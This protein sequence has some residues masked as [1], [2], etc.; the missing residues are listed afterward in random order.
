ME[1]IMNYIVRGQGLGIKFLLLFSLI[2]TIILSV[3]IKNIS[4][5]YFVPAA[6]EAANAILPIKVENGEIVEPLNVVKKHTITFGENEDAE[7]LDITLDTTAYDLD[8]SDLSEGVYITRTSVYAVRDN[9]TKVYKI[10]GTY[11]LP[12]G[13]YSEFISSTLNWTI[14]AV[15]VVIFLGLSLL[16]FIAAIFYATCSYLVSMIMR[17]KYSYD[18]R[19]RLTVLAFITTYVVFIPLNIFGYGSKL[20][21]FLAVLALQGVCMKFIPS[22]EQK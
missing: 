14:L 22:Q 15:G 17:K 1:K 7:H 13:D 18:L 21:F 10:E 8:L 4:D 2:S 5:E 3:N 9:E 6:Q 20:V 19:M 11:E 16:L 12:Q